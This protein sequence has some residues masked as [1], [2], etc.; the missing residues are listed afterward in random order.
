MSG[1]QLDKESQQ[2]LEDL[3]EA[4]EE[5]DDDW[6]QVYGWTQITHNRRGLVL[7][8]GG[9]EGGIHMSSKKELY[10][11]KRNWGTPSVIDKDPIMGMRLVVKVDD[12]GVFAKLVP[13]PL[14]SQKTLKRYNAMM[15]D[16]A[17][18]GLRYH[19][20]RRSTM[21]SDVARVQYKAMADL[22]YPGLFS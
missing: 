2:I 13:E 21:Y 20:G 1:E 18:Y 12:D 6:Q 15:Y 16:N 11:W 4:L 19:E 8:G 9:P 7:F 17:I 14:V 3:A 22:I 10:H 5:E